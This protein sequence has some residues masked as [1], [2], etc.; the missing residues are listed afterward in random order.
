LYAKYLVP[1]DDLVDTIGRRGEGWNHLEIGKGANGQYHA[2]PW[3]FISFQIGENLPDTWED[4]H[5]IG[6]KLKA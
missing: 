1:L 2:L 6:Q 5:R 4:V 3:Y